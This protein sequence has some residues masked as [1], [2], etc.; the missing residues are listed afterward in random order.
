[1]DI[2]ATV[3]LEDLP[4]VNRELNVR[5]TLA[6][7]YST[8]EVRVTLWL[9]PR[10]IWTLWYIMIVQLLDDNGE[11]RQGEWF[12]PLPNDYIL[13]MWEALA[14]VF[15]RIGVPYTVYLPGT[16]LSPWAFHII[17]ELMEQDWGTLPPVFDFIGDPP[18]SSNLRHMLH[19]Y[20]NAGGDF[21]LDSFPFTQVE[22]LPGPP[23]PRPRTP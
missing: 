4:L 17:A 10:R 23:V 5:G 2:S 16:R 1:M 15:R 3:P 6:L 19:L 11:P 12:F 22:R 18:L 20:S 14:H 7:P 21:L 8:T 13:P 9:I